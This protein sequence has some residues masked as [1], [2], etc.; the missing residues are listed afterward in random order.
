MG[1]ERACGTYL[2]D[3]FNG[4]LDSP[5]HLL[6]DLDWY[7]NPFENLDLLDHLDG[8]FHSLLHLHLYV[9]KT[10]RDIRCYSACSKQTALEALQGCVNV[11]TALLRARPEHTC[12]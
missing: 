3:H 12:L 11:C 7:F 8:H 6:D 4:D 9:A 2:F 10:V 1:S 5:L